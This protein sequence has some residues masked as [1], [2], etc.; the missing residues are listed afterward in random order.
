MADCGCG[1]SCKEKVLFAC[2]GAADVG[3]LSDKV[4]RKLR[5]DGFGKMSC[6]IGIGAKLDSFL[7]TA[8]NSNTIVIDGCS[9][10]CGK[11]A[12]E[13]AGITA[14]IITLTEMG[15]EKGKTPVTDELVNKTAESIK[16]SFK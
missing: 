12:V 6:L 3:E 1:G 8:K 9:V 14:N 15:M 16:K 10:N 5:K 11:K 7:Q 2:S 4:A 13:A